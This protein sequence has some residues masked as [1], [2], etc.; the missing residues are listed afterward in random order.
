M[1]IFHLIEAIKPHNKHTDLRVHKWL[2]IIK[3]ELKNDYFFRTKK[4]IKM[5]VCFT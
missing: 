5:Y 4:L 2:N 3:S 1:T